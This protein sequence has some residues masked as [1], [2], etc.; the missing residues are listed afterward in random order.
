[1]F[2]LC[3]ICLSMHYPYLLTYSYLHLMLL[4]LELVVCTR[5][6]HFK[7]YL[8]FLSNPEFVPNGL[9]FQFALFTPCG[10]IS[11]SRSCIIKALDVVNYMLIHCALHSGFE[12][13][14]RSQ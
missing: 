8:F 7:K 12:S 3:D 4:P 11:F 9:E 13:C 6:G 2:T 14:A 5:E 10:S 1:M